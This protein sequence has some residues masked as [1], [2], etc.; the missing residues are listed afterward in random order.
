VE[1]ARE[2]L[3]RYRARVLAGF[4]AGAHVRPSEVS[5]LGQLE[6]RLAQLEMFEQARDFTR[7]PTLN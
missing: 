4:D 2:L 1:R 6:I 5:A 3:D 7:R